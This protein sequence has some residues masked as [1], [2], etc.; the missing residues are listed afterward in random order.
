MEILFQSCYRPDIST[1]VILG[2]T[3]NHHQKLTSGHHLPCLVSHN[4][5]I[6]GKKKKNKGE[7]GKKKI[8][9]RKKEKKE[10]A[11]WES[12]F[13]FSFVYYFLETEATL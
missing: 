2:A 8:E 4:V 13:R 11:F 7:N 12:F 1:L 10:A 6:R 5:V 9:K 3:F